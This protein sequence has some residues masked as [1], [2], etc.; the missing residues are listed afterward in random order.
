LTFS[1]QGLKLKPGL[2][3]VALSDI[4]ELAKGIL[5]VGDG[6]GAPQG[7]TVGDD[8]QVLTANSGEAT[9]LKWGAAG[10]GDIVLM[11]SAAFTVTETV[12]TEKWTKT[13]SADDF[14]ANDKILVIGDNDSIIG[15]IGLKEKIRIY[16]GT[17][18]FTSSEGNLGGVVHDQTYLQGYD[19]ILTF[20]TNILH[21]SVVR[22][23]QLNATMID[24]WITSA[25]TISGRYLV[26]ANDTITKIAVYKIKA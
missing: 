13:F 2:S 17:N 19:T 12:E 7:L 22:R 15:G 10:G 18:T 21:P 8:T 5:I 4:D 26:D 6:S 3:A 9:G 24:S 16:D 20:S 14:A 25:F 1:I 23:E 11:H